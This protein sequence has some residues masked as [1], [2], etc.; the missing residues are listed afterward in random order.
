[1]TEKELLEHL[2]LHTDRIKDLEDSIRKLER[3]L[4]DGVCKKCGGVSWDI[5]LSDY[6]QCNPQGQSAIKVEQTER[7]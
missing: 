3:I 5:K 7:V 2:V 6:C 1:M 4:Q